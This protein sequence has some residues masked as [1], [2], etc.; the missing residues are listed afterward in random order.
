MLASR[1]DLDRKSMKRSEAPR[2]R[3]ALAAVPRFAS[4]SAASGS[5]AISTVATAIHA[6]RFGRGRAAEA[7]A[8][9]G[10]AARPVGR[11]AASLR[12]GL[13]R[14]DPTIQKLVLLLFLRHLW[15]DRRHVFFLRV[16]ILGAFAA[17]RDRRVGRRG[18]I[19]RRLDSDQGK[20]HPGVNHLHALLF[21]LL[22]H[23][24]HIADLRGVR[25]D[26]QE[27]GLEVDPVCAGPLLD[28]ARLE[29]EVS[30]D[31]EIVPLEDADEVLVIR[32]AVAVQVD[33]PGEGDVFLLARTERDAE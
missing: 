13:R 21:R 5:P 32:L 28:L 31:D 26:D 7:E 11:A 17:Q 6:F 20:E 14:P 27:L 19:L 25:A 2:R 33:D 16:H 29:V 3:L 4:A 18:R 10:T 30:V 1:E 9:R 22:H 12:F 15:N 23:L 8:K 24:G